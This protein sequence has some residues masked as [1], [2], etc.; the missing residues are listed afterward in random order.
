M[1]EAILKVIKDVMQLTDLSD[2]KKLEI[3]KIINTPHSIDTINEK[4]FKIEY[5]NGKIDN[6]SFT[7]EIKNTTVK[8]K[9][10]K[11]KTIFKIYG[12]TSDGQ[13]CYITLNSNLKC[14][15]FDIEYPATPASFLEE[16]DEIKKILI[17]YGIKYF[18]NPIFD[19][20]TMKTK[21]IVNKI[22]QLVQEIN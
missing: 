14:I 3:V 6:F 11:A 17:D 9:F 12:Y 18:N 21:E 13:F 22:N 8:L 2:E 15:R 5:Y 1:S 4:D 16:P 19:S 10:M 20:K 7:T